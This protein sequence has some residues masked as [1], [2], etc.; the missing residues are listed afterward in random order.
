MGRL[1]RANPGRTL[2]EIK[3]GTHHPRPCAP[4]AAISHHFGLP[5]CKRP[6]AAASC[7]RHTTFSAPQ[8]PGTLGEQPDRS[9]RN[10]PSAW[11]RRARVRARVLPC[12]SACRGSTTMSMRAA[13]ASTGALARRTVGK[14]LK[15]C[16]AISSRR[17]QKP[18]IAAGRCRAPAATALPTG[19]CAR[20]LLPATCG[21]GRPGREAYSRIS[22]KFAS[23]P[24]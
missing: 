11:A 8:T 12:A 21:P 23:Y 3:P 16:T 7:C 10:G 24:S 19:I 18:R 1:C 17:F 20:I 13:A 4:Q 9:F 2:T 22:R 15:L 14:F 6:P 5:P